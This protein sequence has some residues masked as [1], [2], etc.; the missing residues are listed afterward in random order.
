MRKFCFFLSLFAIV[1]IVEAQD[2]DC[3]IKARAKGIEAYNQKNY[4]KAKEMF[5]VA[6]RCATLPKH[7]DIDNWIAKCDQGMKAKIE[8]VSQPNTQKKE[9][10][11]I[12][13]N[14]TSRTTCSSNLMGLEIT[15]SFNVENMKGQA[16][17]S[18]C[19][20]Y[21][22]YEYV[23]FR[24]DDEWDNIQYRLDDFKERGMHKKVT[25]SYANTPY[26]V[27]GVPGQTGKVI[28][29]ERDFE[30]I[31]ET[32][33]IPF[34]AMNILTF[35]K[36]VFETMVVAYKSSKSS[37]VQKD[38]QKN[39]NY[40]YT[41][42]LDTVMTETFIFTPINLEI[43]N[44]SNDKEIT[45]SYGGGS[46]DLRIKVCG[47]II[48][49]DLPSWLHARQSSATIIVDENE[50]TTP[51]YA[52]VV[53]RP[54]DGSNPVKLHITQE[55]A[56]ELIPAT[57][58]RVRT[59]YNVGP[60]NNK[61]TVFHVDLDVEG[62]KNKNVRV[63]AVFYNVDD[64]TPLLDSSGNPI[65]A[66]SYGTPTNNSVNF[67]D[68]KIPISNIRFMSAANLQQKEVKVYVKVS[69]DKGDSF[70]TEDGPYTI[71]WE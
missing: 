52:T 4:S 40:E 28:E 15:A 55:A 66:F 58:N 70:V 42:R 64:R 61:Q 25:E 11:I 2:F 27:N 6:K 34:G 10:R 13:T 19:Y 47:E 36:Q 24:I 21:P 48:W 20:L 14:V 69:L 31:T 57:I 67:P 1:S 68:F 59:E 50:S 8:R 16:M 17:E 38:M 44:S 71:K 49:E 63:Y 23:E 9:G 30:Q 53:V 18:F 26:N 5:S 32:Y 7:V 41:P 37:D 29:I 65:D 56:P 43:E 39:E 51:R 45:L 22:E 12:C 62:Q 3:Y 35:D 33:F 60:D 46:L 54:A